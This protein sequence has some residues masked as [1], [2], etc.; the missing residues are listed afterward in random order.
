LLRRILQNKEY[1][2]I[3]NSLQSIGGGIIAFSF[4]FLANLL[5][6]RW[7]GPEEFGKY[8]LIMAIANILVVLFILDTDV[9]ILYFT[10]K[11]NS[12]ITKK[13]FISA[14]LFLVIILTVVFTTLLL[15]LVGWLSSLLNISVHFF[16]LALIMAFLITAKR[17]MDS[18]LKG[19]GYFLNQALGKIIEGV[20]VVVVLLY[21]FIFLKEKT[22]F[23]YVQGV[24]IGGIFAIVFYWF[25]I[26][27]YCIIKNVSRQKIQEVIS[28]G[29]FGL[30]NSAV[31][32][33]LKSADKII[34]VNWLG[35]YNLGIYTAYYTVLILLSARLV[36]LISGVYFPS[37]NKLTN[38]HKIFKRIN[39]FILRAGTLIVLI[40]F[41]IALFLIKFFGQAYPVNAEWIFLG[42]LYFLFH[43]IANLYG[44]LL[45][46]YAHDGYYFKN[47]GDIISGVTFVG[48]IVGSSYLNIFSIG[49][50]FF[51]FFM[52]RFVVSVFYLILLYK[53][54]NK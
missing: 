15:F 35:S 21:F 7:L 4:L 1:K 32:I 37:I 31:T 8:T 36:Q 33:T 34:V 27:S 25:K 13:R 9:S 22:Y 43:L 53:K 28:Y 26:K 24:I 52:S 12:N 3:K 42:S 39:T 10:S 49:C 45:A 14:I 50:V 46:S 16:Y 40:D 17:I 48:I 41:T 19:L 30:V 38:K 47:I 6:G 2:F 54:Y 18:I 5:A 51:G 23:S 29:R 20:I 11:K 44:W